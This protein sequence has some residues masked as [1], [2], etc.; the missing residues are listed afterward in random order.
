MAKKTKKTYKKSDLTTGVCWRCGE[1]SDKIVKGDGRCV[2]C[3]EEDELDDNSKEQVMI[4]ETTY[5][6]LIYGVCDH[7]GCEC[8]E[9][10]PNSGW[11][12]DCIEE[13]RFYQE[14]MR[15]AEKSFKNW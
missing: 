15:M 3:F 5:T 9:I 12:I 2:Y 4:V 8:S 10:D 11:C 13:E 1:Y 7:C 6:D 14:S